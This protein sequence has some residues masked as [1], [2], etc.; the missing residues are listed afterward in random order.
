MTLTKAMILFFLTVIALLVV[1]RYVRYRRSFRTWRLMA[2]G[3]G[4]PIW[5]EKATKSQAVDHCY[6]TYGEVKYVDDKYGLIFF[7]P[8]S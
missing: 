6:R 3:G 7:K 4:S 8:R 1:R 5:L 2:Y